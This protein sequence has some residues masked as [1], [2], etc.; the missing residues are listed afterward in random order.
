MLQQYEIRIRGRV[1]GVGFRYF[2]RSKARDLQITGYARNTPAGE[3]TVV[4]EGEQ[5]DLDTL[6]DFL[7]I[8]PPLANVRELEIAISPYTGHY[9]NFNITF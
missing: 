1:Q 2:V 3:V 7:R 4:A 9:G 8:G 5:T 6:V